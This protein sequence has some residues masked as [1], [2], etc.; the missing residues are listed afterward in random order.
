LTAPFLAVLFVGNVVMGSLLISLTR[1]RF[2]E[3]RAS[4]FFQV[5]LV[6]VFAFGMLVAEVSLLVGVFAE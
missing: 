6:V 1:Q 4:P 3:F 5:A 2:P